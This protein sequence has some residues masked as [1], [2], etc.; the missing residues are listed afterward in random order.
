MIAHCSDTLSSCE[1]MLAVYFILFHFLRRSLI[2]PR[3]VLNSE[4]MY[5]HLGRRNLNKVIA[6][7]RLALGY[8]LGGGAFS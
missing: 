8:V 7:I 5:Y 1:R 2:Y 3:L 6:S 4:M